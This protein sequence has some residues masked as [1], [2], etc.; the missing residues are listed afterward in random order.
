MRIRKEIIMAVKILIKRRLPLD[1]D[2]Y[3]VELLRQLRTLAMQQEGYISGET[4]RS[5]ENSEEFLVIST[6]R[7]FED[8]RNWLNNSQREGLQSKVDIL[9]GRRTTYEA[10]QQGFTA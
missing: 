10:Y 6:W 4:L 7:S 5:I 3:A 8:W 1:K 2:K 9:S